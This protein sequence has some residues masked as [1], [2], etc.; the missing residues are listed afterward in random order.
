MVIGES[1]EVVNP[2]SG[3]AISIQSLLNMIIISL[4]V[5]P[6]K[7]IPMIAQIH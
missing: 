3:S 6:G 4:I 7:D 1:G 2:L 5:I